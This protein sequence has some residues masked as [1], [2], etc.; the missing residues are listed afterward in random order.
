MMRSDF[1]YGEVI[2]RSFAWKC[3]Y[4]IFFPYEGVCPK[5]VKLSH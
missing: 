1:F 3:G 5:R 2:A 4:A